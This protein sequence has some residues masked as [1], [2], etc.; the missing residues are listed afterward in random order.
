MALPEPVERYLAHAL[1]SGP[2]PDPAVRLRMTGRIKLGAWLRFTAEQ[3]CDARSFVWRARVGPMHVTDRFAGGAGATEGR[4]FGRRTVF[5]AHGDDIGRSSAGRA[6]L[7]A[8]WAPAALLPERGVSWRA[9]SDELIVATRD[10]P[11]ERPEVR[12]RIGHDGALRAVSALRWGNAGRRSFGYIPCGCEVVA[13]RRF[14]D[15][16]VPSEVTVGWWFGTPDY[17]P[18]FRARVEDLH[19]V[20]A[21]QRSQMR[22]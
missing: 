20:P 10:V 14:G 15:L 4:L 8:I 22:T 12:L 7:E 3:Q 19:A 11:P 21:L 9:E 1:P 5:D 2:P 17:A 6:A 18:F 13:E 16:V